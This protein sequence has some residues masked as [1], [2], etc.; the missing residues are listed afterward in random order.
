MENKTVSVGRW[1]YSEPVCESK[2]LFRSHTNKDGIKPS[3][4]AYMGRI[5][6]SYGIVISTGCPGSTNLISSFM[7]V[8]AVTSKPPSLIV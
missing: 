4:L 7:M 1:H 5:R 2:S 3:L 6:H 8:S